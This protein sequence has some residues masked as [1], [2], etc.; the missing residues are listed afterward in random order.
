M[1]ASSSRERA[2]YQQQQQAAAAAQIA[3]PA[4][5][6]HQHHAPPAYPDAYPPPP[7]YRPPQ[8]HGQAPNYGGGP[9][10]YGVQ[11]Q[12]GWRPVYPPQFPGGQYYPVPYQMQP[13]PPPPPAAAPPAMR[14]A[15]VP[16]EQL[17]QTA[18]IRNS[19]NL[20]KNSL[21]LVPVDGNPRRLAVTFTFDSSVPCR[22]TV[23]VVAVEEPSRGCAITQTQG[24]PAPA[25]TYGDGGRTMLG[26]AYPPPGAAAAVV[27]LDCYDERQL[28]APDGGAFPLIVRMET[29][30]EKGLAEGHSLQ[31]LEVG[32]G[33]KSWVQSQTTFAALARDEHAGPGGL[34]ARVLKQ[35]IWVEGVS[36]ELQ[37]IYGI[38]SLN[39]RHRLDV[40]A[41]E[42]ELSEEKLCVICL[43][44]RRDTT[45]LPCRHLC[46]CQDCAQE[47]RRHNSKCPGIGRRDAEARY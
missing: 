7:V 19:V 24:P 31:E 17:L 30:T 9:Q 23:F 28:I 26:K 39:S 34:R 21:A 42:E 45:V 8:Y 41:P 4:Q 16:Q 20:K 32:A 29:V 1:G 18:T 46:M 37:E 3:G 27:D 40:A 6:Q 5:L 25:V 14:P 36:Y 12:G 35:K 33:Q 10:F 2:R 13:P 44:N 43:V 15:A 22:V 11:H 47:L 38:D